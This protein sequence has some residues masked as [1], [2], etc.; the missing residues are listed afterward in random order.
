MLQHS[1]CVRGDGSSG[2]ELRAS[3]GSAVL[4]CVVS[5]AYEACGLGAY[6]LFIIVVFLVMSA[7][8]PCKGGVL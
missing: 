8:L 3:L 5:V 7:D 6:F 2:L 4:Q 1:V